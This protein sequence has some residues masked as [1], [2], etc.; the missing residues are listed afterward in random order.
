MLHLTAADLK[1]TKIESLVIPVCEDKEIHDNKTISALIRDV[2]K[3]KEFKGDKGDEVAFYNLPE[4]KAV[5]G[6]FLGIGKFE[7]IDLEALRSLTGKAIKIISKK[8]LAEVGI[9]VP[10]ARQ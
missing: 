2:M 3:I 6:M 7:N 4:V 5:R 1:K 8:K 9:A 10:S